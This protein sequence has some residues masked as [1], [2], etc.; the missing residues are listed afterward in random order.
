MDIVHRVGSIFFFIFQISRNFLYIII[1][2]ENNKRAK[3]SCKILGI[4]RNITEA[5]NG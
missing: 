1:I 3:F 2:V 4:F 5:E